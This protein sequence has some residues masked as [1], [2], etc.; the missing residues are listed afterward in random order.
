MNTYVRVSFYDDNGPFAQLL[1]VQG[2]SSIQRLGSY[3]ISYEINRLTGVV[4]KYWFSDIGEFIVTKNNIG[5]SIVGN[6]V[7]KLNMARYSTDRD[8]IRAGVYIR[9]NIYTA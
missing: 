7:L 2:D 4:T 5:R 9:G 3:L 1:S 8:T 6:I